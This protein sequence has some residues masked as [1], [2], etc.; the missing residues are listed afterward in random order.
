MKFKLLVG[1]HID[2][3][4]ADREQARKEGRK[5]R[6]KVYVEGDIIETHLDLCKL[7][8]DDPSMRK[9]FDRL[10]DDYVPPPPAPKAPPAQAQQPPAKVTTNDMTVLESMTEAELRK[11]CAEEEID[12]A[13]VKGGK[14]GILK[15]L[16]GMAV[17]AK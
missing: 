13:G 10:P 6:D 4:P 9:K 1:K 5:P 17:G 12:L 11:Y 3:D 7:N 2:D 16:K 14:D 8:P 15:A